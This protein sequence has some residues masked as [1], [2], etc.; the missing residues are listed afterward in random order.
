MSCGWSAR[1]RHPALHCDPG[2]PGCGGGGDAHRENLGVPAGLFS[3]HRTHISTFRAS[4]RFTRA[5][6]L[7]RLCR[8]MLQARLTTACNRQGLAG[9]IAER[10]IERP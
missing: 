7:A 5:E 9:A 10:A 6:P 3:L 2:H 1:P 4:H 8:A